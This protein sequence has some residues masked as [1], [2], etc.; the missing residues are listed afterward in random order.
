MNTLDNS[1]E[2]LS[3]GAPRTGRPVIPATE[4]VRR[5]LARC[6]AARPDYRLGR[7]DEQ[8]LQDLRKTANI[9]R[10]EARWW[11]VLVNQARVADGLPLPY[12]RAALR[13]SSAAE[14]S[15]SHYDELAEK[16]AAR[17]SGGGR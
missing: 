11:N 1:F 16:T 12:F 2:S 13:A 4:L 15:A 8:R 7:S 9:Y 17:L 10:R 3:S 5:G 6:D 14:Q